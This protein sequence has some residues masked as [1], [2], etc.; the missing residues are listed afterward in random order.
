MSSSVFSAPFFLSSLSGT[1][2]M[3][4]SEHLICLRGLSDWTHFSPL[5]SACMI[6]AVQSSSLLIHSS[7]AFLLECGFLLI[8]GF[9][10]EYFLNFR[11]YILQLYFVLYNFQLSVNS[12]CSS[13]FLS[14]FLSIFMSITLYCL[15]DRLFVSIL[16]SSSGVLYCSFICSTFL[17]CLFWSNFVIYFCVW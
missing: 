17:C 5:C 16:L 7:V 9:L 15:S 2:I 12:L 11:Y 8:C 3:W 10:L 13:I 14:S 4:M 1:P 6:S